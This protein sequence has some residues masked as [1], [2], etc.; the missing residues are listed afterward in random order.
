MVAGTIYTYPGSFRGFKATIAANVSGAAVKT[1]ELTKNDKHAHVPSYESDDKKYTLFD[2]NAIAYYL[3]NDQMRGQSAEDKA[4]VVQWL[5]YGSEHAIN[6]VAGWVYPSLSLMETCQPGLQKA[7]NDLRQVFACVNEHL[8]TRTFLVGERMTLADVSLACDLLM[9]LQHV[10]DPTFRKPFGNLTRWF[11][12]VVNQEA[13]KKVL[14]EVTLCTVCPEFCADKHAKQTAAAAAAPAKKAKEPKV[15]EAKPPKEK[16]PKSDVEEEDEIMAAEPK[17]NDPFAA[18]PKGT[19]NM[20]EFKRT[21]SNEDTL[22]VALP[23][24][25]KNFEENTEFYSIWYC[26]YKYPE[27]LSKVFMTSNLI[28]GMFQRIEKL[29]KNSFC[30]MGV[31]GVDGKNTISGIWFW[32]GQDLVFPLCSDWTTDYES[33]EW[34]K[35][36]ASNAEHK[37]M[38]N[39]CWQWEGEVKGMKFN[40]GKTFK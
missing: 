13:V 32:K 6:A 21:Y 2:A 20:D 10:A 5:N 12:T 34:K 15:K 16:K 14:G 30:N 27:D 28:G 33:Y 19:F 35:L 9:A 1:V 26:E 38:L 25:W 4:Q 11:M 7:K 22:K 37:K 39:E 29:R 18:M 17:S 23:Y 40:T 3:A 31:Y 24:F 36:D 8:K